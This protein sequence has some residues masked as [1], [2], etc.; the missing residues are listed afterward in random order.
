MTSGVTLV[1]RLHI[2]LMRTRADLC[3]GAA[4]AR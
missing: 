3:A 1:A 2:D 4:P